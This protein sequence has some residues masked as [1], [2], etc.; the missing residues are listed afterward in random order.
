MDTEQR[1]SV[2]E[3]VGWNG[4]SQAEEAVLK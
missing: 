3:G 1:A 4:Q 2:L